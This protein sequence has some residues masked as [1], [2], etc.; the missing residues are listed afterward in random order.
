MTSQV[1]VSKLDTTWNTRIDGIND[2][3]TLSKELYTAAGVKDLDPN[4]LYRFFEKGA[5]IKKFDSGDTALHA[6]AWNGDDKKLSILLNFAADASLLNDQNI[7]PLELAALKSHM[8]CVELLLTKSEFYLDSFL[9]FKSMNKEQVALFKNFLKQADLSP[10]TIWEH[11]EHAIKYHLIEMI[12]A[13]LEHGVSINFGKVLNPQF[14]TR[15]LF[16]SPTTPDT[17]RIYHQNL[18][19][20]AIEADNLKM[21]QELVQRGADHSIRIYLNID[22]TCSLAEWAQYK[23]LYSIAEYLNSLSESSQA[24]S[25]SRKRQRSKANSE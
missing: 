24:S 16:C 13:L 9:E 19:F 10:E 17:R 2:P 11:F 22:R 5:K 14:D 20:L 23:G 1:T 6:A 15:P 8:K 21:V 3:K 12:D 7:S 18:L 4:V 25:S